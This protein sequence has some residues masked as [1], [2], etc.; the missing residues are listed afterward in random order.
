MH[1][2]T[3][4]LRL[5]LNRLGAAKQTSMIAVRALRMSLSVMV[6]AVQHR[7]GVARHFFVYMNHLGTY[8]DR[9]RAR[10]GIR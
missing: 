7:A 9:M 6:H 5:A 1:A 10:R 3:A 2:A 4:A 8:I